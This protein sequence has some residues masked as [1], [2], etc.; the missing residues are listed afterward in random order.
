MRQNWYV[1]SY[2]SSIPI[3]VLF[4]AI[5]LVFGSPEPRDSASKQILMAPV[6]P[7][8]ELQT[9]VTTFT[10][11]WLQFWEILPFKRGDKH[12]R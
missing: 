6:N 5:S 9:H 3:Q 11:S 1:H 10:P 7:N 2:C 8:W 4:L 12:P